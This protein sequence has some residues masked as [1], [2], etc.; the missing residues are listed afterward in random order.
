MN[1]LK[2]LIVEDEVL[3]A[4]TIKIYLEERGHSITDAVISY[5]EA[6]QTIKNN[7]PDLALIDIRLYGQKSG[8][9]LAEEITKQNYNLPYVFL[10]S[11]FDTRIL[12]RA[13][14]SKPH[15]YLI[16]P[17]QKESLWTTMELAHHNFT[18]SEEENKLKISDG[19]NTYFLQSDDIMYISADHIYVNIHTQSKGT[20]VIRM[21]LT[22]LYNKLDS[23]QFIQ[24]HRSYI[25]NLKYV[26]KYDVNSFTINDEIIPVSRGNKTEIK[27][28]LENTN[29][30]R[31][32]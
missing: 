7:K 5:E 17:I 24:C 21:T 25:V 29:E 15:G 18:L 6:M 19:S 31:V 4:E 12:N 20:I 32:Q 13:M 11:Q 1:P 14:E 23:N 28:I 27:K 8:I 3:I 10:T 16:K 9:D 2:I 26:S 22:D 30:N